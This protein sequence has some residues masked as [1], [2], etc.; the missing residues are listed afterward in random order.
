VL[1]IMGSFG[2]DVARYAAHHPWAARL[3]READIGAT[4]QGGD[5]RLSV[6]HYPLQGWID[7]VTM[8]V[9]MGLA[10]GVQLEEFA[11]VSYAPLGEAF[12]DIAP[13]ERRHAELGLEGLAKIA[14]T[15][16]GRAEARRAIAYWRPRVAASFGAAGSSRFDTLKR[17]GLRHKPNETLLGEWSAKLDSALGGLG[18]T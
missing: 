11:K 2:A 10:V 15:E 16:Q 14:A 8:N 5:M 6:F 7:A 9:L 17:F 3:D 4:R 18:L 13:R 1:E 12:R